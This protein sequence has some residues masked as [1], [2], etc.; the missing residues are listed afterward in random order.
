MTPT[1]PN[2]LTR[3]SELPSAGDQLF[4]TQED[5]WNNACV[6]WCRDGWSL[7]ARGYKD[8]ADHLVK[9]VVERR[10]HQDVLVYPILFL[11]RQFLELQIKELIRL[12]NRLLD[13]SD[14]VPKHHRISALWATCRPML[15][16]IAP[17]DSDSELDD[18]GRLIGDFSRVDPTSTAFRYPEDREGN[19]SLHGLSH[20]NLR[21]VR[22][23]IAKMSILL[24]GADAMLGEYLQHKLEMESEFRGDY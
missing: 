20:I 14:G 15:R 1:D 8:A 24:T 6:N 3:P 7:Y 4:C 16:E 13:K 23:V 9:H 10:A 12:A 21:N 5:W 18:V 17:G 2:E 22:D 11:Y 19:P